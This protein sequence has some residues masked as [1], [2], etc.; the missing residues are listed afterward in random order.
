MSFTVEASCYL[1]IFD[2]W[3]RV[4]P[5]DDGSVVNLVNRF[6][7]QACDN[8]FEVL[9]RK[10]L[11]NDVKFAPL[12]LEVFAAVETILHLYLAAAVVF[13]IRR[14]WELKAME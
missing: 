3:V 10:N 2:G 8:T 6:A 13:L 5:D 9:C 1:S 12:T 14:E 7:D 4:L 11:Q